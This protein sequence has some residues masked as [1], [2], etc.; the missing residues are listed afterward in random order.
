MNSNK[1]KI[2]KLNV[3]IKPLLKT[4]NKW[5]LSQTFALASWDVI[6]AW[7]NRDTYNISNFQNYNTVINI[8]RENGQIELSSRLE[9]ALSSREF[10][11][12]KEQM[13][14]FATGLLKVSQLFTMAQLGHD[15]DAGRQ[16]FAKRD[17][18]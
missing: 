11:D 18:Y 12:S 2:E 1:L 7:Q 6:F 13:D 4:Y 15:Y 10:L 14:K 5:Y 3:T 9:L 16:V 17:N 8:L